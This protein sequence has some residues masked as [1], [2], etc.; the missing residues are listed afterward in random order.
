MKLCEKCGACNSDDRFFCVDC[1]EKLG[2]KATPAL[3]KQLEHNID[4]AID[5]L[6]DEK[7]PLNVNLLDRIT[8]FWSLAGLAAAVFVGF[9]S[10]FMYFVYLAVIFVPSLTD[11][12]LP[13][14][15]WELHKLRLGFSV[16]NADNATPSDLYRIMRRVANVILCIMGTVLAVFIIYGGIFHPESF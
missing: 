1:N 4:N 11:S 9:K 12:F 10:G 16:A 2:E 6:Y 3:E 8:G 5:R 7:D 15:A 13:T 14:L